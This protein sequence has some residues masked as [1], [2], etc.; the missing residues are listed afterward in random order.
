MEIRSSVNGSEE[1]SLGA[2]LNKI[3]LIL[4][5]P[6]LEVVEET[7]K[8]EAVDH[9]KKED[10][11]EKTMRKKMESK[12]SEYAQRKDEERLNLDPNELKLLN[13]TFRKE[14]KINGSIGPPNQNNRLT[15]TSLRRQIQEGEIISGVIKA[16]S[17]G[18]PI[19]S[20]LEMKQD[21]NLDYL[22]DLLRSHYQEKNAA[23]Q[24]MELQ[25]MCQRDHENAQD[26]LFR[27]LGLRQKVIILSKE[28]ASLPCEP[29]LVQSV[30]RRTLETG[31]K[32]EQVLAKILPY[33]EYVS[34]DDDQLLIN[35]VKLAITADSERN[36]ILR[37]KSKS[38]KVNEVEVEEKMTGKKNREESL[39]DAIGS[40]SK[41]M[42]ALQTDIE[43]LKQGKEKTF[44]NTSNFRIIKCKNCMEANAQRCFH[45][46]KC[47]SNDHFSSKCDA[48]N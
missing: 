5:V 46:W 37:Q 14:F 12:N 29:E 42:E 41:K 47:G 1:E 30:F 35:Q 24:L 34:I 45:C 23:E 6:P 22:N 3:K 36:T 38:Y 9:E 33:L 18:L 44:R 25:N 15:Y 19:R 2:L 8:H 10:L 17:P 40:L 7:G 48:L 16:I 39:F 21:I 28:D 13:S 4:E 43:V 11:V 31:I 20:Y 27:A 26:F 32:E